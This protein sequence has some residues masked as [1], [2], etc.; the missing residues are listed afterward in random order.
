MQ[1]IEINRL[2]FVMEP[3]SRSLF[4]CEVGMEYFF[5]SVN[6]QTS[7]GQALTLPM[8]GTESNPPRQLTACHTHLM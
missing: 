7:S 5:L 3:W 2:V 6:I 4:F 1:N 8:H